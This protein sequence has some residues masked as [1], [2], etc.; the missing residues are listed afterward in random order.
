MLSLLLVLAADHAIDF[1]RDIRPLLADRCFAC[2]GPD[3]K[4]RKG[5]LRLDLREEAVRKKAIVPGHPERSELIARVAS[6]DP[7][8][9]MPPPRLGKALKPAEADL[10]RRWIKQGAPYARHWAWVKPARPPVPVMERAAN[11]IDAFLWVRLRKEGLEPSPEAD[12]AAL[13]RRAWID[14]AGLPPTVEEADRFLADARPDAYE[15]SIDRVLASPAFG[16]RW[17]VTW[18][19]LARYADSQGYANDP[20]RS[21]WPWRDWVIRSLNANLPYDRFTIEQL[22]GDLLPGAT[23]EQRLATGFHRNTLTNTEGGTNAEEFRTAAV[24]DRVNTTFQ[25]WMGTT[26]ACAQCHNHKYDPYSQ[27]EYY[28]AYA[29]FNS[30]EDANGG[31]DAPT[32]RIP[33]PGKASELARLQAEAKAATDKKKKA[34][35]EARIKTLAM[36]SPVLK[37][38]A[39]PRQTHVLLRGEWES[40]GEKVSPGLPALFGTSPPKTD[41][42]AF[43]RWI[44]SEDNPLTARVAVNRLWEEVFG[45][46]LVETSEEF[47]TQGDPPSHPELLDWLAVEFARDWD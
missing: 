37:E 14:L 46:G 19:D 7:R 26:M 30:C 24:V 2:H 16:E 29:V 13:L 11:P 39:K 32:V 21:I 3:D 12:R 33:L 6:T 27:K 20:D 5:K 31:N 18:L 4:A 15:R 8:E 40:K 47:G 28:Q 44:A 22:A 42:L 35:L 38:L 10:L 1:N 17:A 9:A 45:I 25:T 34:D 41:R 36:E 43:A 23:D